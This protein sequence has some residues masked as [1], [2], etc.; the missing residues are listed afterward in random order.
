RA[1]RL[2]MVLFL[3]GLTLLLVGF[4]RPEATLRSER[5][6]ATVVLSIDTSGSMDTKDVKPTRLLAARDA[7]LT[8]LDELPKKY[9]VALETFSD[10]PAVLVPP[11]Y[12]R[13]RLPASPPVKAEIARP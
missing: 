11:T 9:K 5:E 4:A 12:D 1:R 6:G 2:P 13:K 7:A 8:F 10:H 3:L